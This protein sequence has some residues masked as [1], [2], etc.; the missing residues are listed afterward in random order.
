VH[1]AQAW[2][3]L[4]QRLGYSEYV[5]QG[6]DWGA[7]V[8]QSMGMQAP[9]GLLGI[10]SNMPGT[11]PLDIVPGFEHGDPPPSGL[12][13]EERSA[14]DQLSPSTRSTWRTPRSCRPARRRSTGC[15]THPSTL[16]AFMLDHGDGTGQP[17]L[18][19]KVLESDLDSDL[20]RTT[21][22]TTSRCT[23]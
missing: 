16:A 4:M 14:Y 23:G 5:A 1:I 2:A 20:T 17:G 10:H 3:E 22:S 11:A 7:A 18:V 6:G 13:D 12:S 19:E 8:T 15:R 9:P 21:F